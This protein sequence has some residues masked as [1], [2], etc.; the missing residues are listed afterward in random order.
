MGNGNGGSKRNRGRR[1]QGVTPPVFNGGQF[2]VHGRFAPAI[3]RFTPGFSLGIMPYGS[4]P[5]GRRTPGLTGPPGGIP[6]WGPTQ[7]HLPTG[8]YGSPCPAAKPQIPH[9]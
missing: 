7:Y 9:S 5:Q 1:M 3:G 6:Q 2:H 4:M 8:G